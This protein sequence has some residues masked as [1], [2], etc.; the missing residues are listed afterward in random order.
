MKFVYGTL[1]GLYLPGIRYFPC[2][3]FFLIFPMYATTMATAT[4]IAIQGHAA[5]KKSPAFSDSY[6]TLITET[7]QPSWAST[8]ASSADFGTAS[9]YTSARPSSAM[10]NT[11]G[12]VEAHS[13]QE[14]HPSLLM[15]AFMIILLQINV[16]PFHLTVSGPCVFIRKLYDGRWLQSK[17]PVSA[18]YPEWVIFHTHMHS[19]ILPQS[20]LL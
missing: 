3:C 16:F 7:G 5:A 13:S 10:R 8:A 4:L 1:P 2:S 9:T 6:S 18:L 17:R 19:T 11:S 14:I 20:F 12:Q 15:E